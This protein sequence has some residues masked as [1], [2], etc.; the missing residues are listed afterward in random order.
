MKPVT[1]W[2]TWNELERGWQHNHIED[3]HVDALQTHPKPKGDFPLQKQW[4]KQAWI[5]RHMH[6]DNGVLK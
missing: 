6:I 1:V 2:K 5:K 4:S 3:G